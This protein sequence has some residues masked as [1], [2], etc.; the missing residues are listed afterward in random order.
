MGRR[1]RFSDVREAEEIIRAMMDQYN[2]VTGD[3]ADDPDVYAPILEVDPDSGELCWEPWVEAF[4]RAMRRRADAWGVTR[5]PP[6]GV[7]GAIAHTRT[8]RA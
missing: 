2:R 1:R 8:D 5:K 7:R 3:V 6:Y 4:E